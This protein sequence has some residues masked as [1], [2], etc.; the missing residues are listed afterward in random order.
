[1]NIIVWFVFWCASF[2]LEHYFCHLVSMLQS[3][4]QPK[5][6]LRDCHRPLPYRT[7]WA[8]KVQISF[9]FV[10]LQG[11][12]SKFIFAIRTHQVSASRLNLATHRCL[13]A[14]NN[15]SCQQQKWS[16]ATI[17][18]WEKYVFPFLTL[19]CWLHFFSEEVYYLHANSNI[20]ALRHNLEQPHSQLHAN[21]AP[22][23][24]WD[25]AGLL[26]FTMLFLFENIH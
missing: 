2:L 15:K 4:S 22:S 5:D 11:C 7:P 24:R 9:F 14:A 12:N 17:S 3:A 25:I 6:D 19:M 20:P 8:K 10:D 16:G 21:R 13:P 26:Y 18:K 1:M 23:T